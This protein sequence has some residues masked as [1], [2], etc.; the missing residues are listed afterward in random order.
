MNKKCVT[1]ILCVICLSIA[2]VHGFYSVGRATV[3][4]GVTLGT[5]PHIYHAGIT[6][7]NEESLAIITGTANC[8]VAST[9]LTSVVLEY[10]LDNETVISSRTHNAANNI[11]TAFNFSVPIY[12]TRHSKYLYYRLSVYD[13]ASRVVYWPPAANYYALDVRAPYIT[14]DQIEQV[15]AV[16]GIAVATGTV[17]AQAGLASLDFFYKTDAQ[18]VYSSST[19]SFTD[20][21]TEYVFSMKVKTDTAGAS[22]LQ[23]YFRA[24]DNLNKAGFLPYGGQVFSTPISSVKTVTIGPGGG[25]IVLQDGN[26]EDGETSI[27]IPAGALD[28]NVEITITELNPNDNTIAAGNSP[29]MSRRPFSCFRFTPEGLQ[30][31]K[32]IKINLLYQDTD[33]DGKVDGTDFDEETAKVLWWDN[34]DW[35]YVRSRAD[36]QENLSSGN[37][38]HFSMY[39]VFPARALSDDD[40]RPKERIITPAY[41]DNINDFATFDGLI[42]G[43]IVNIFDVTGRRIRQL[44]DNG[45]TWDGTDDDGSI[46]ESGLYIYQIKVEG[47]LISGTIVVAK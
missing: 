26:C 10:Y 11:T 36:V 17:I 29:A 34:F 43:D 8:G 25:I 2:K 6:S 39:A 16:S 28:S 14:H 12:V 37:I 22:F 20:N 33:Q 24:L 3:T 42:E 45:F 13:T 46:V 44:K 4:A 7:L 41:A 40:Y 19:L 38:K 9:P 1:I 15:S 30:F 23:Y 31:K 21:P 47:R 27:E 5:D 35:R 32:M 18:T